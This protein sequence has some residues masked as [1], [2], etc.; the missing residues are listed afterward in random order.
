MIKRRGGIMIV[1][2]EAKNVLSGIIHHIPPTM[3]NWNYGTEAALFISV[4]AGARRNLIKPGT[5]NK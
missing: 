2:F 3:V 4:S 5:R 1:L